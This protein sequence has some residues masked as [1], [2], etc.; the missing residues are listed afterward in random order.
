MKKILLIITLIFTVTTI[1]T[2]CNNKKED[3]IKGKW[4]ANVENQRKNRENKE[5]DEYVLECNGKGQYDLKKQ[6]QDLA[7]ASYKI[8]KNT[9]TFYDEGRK[10]LALCKLINN[11]ELDCSEKSYYAY[12][13]IKIEQ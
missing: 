11:K 8:E 2:G 9:V 12:K 3:I 1:I 13:Y 7:N 10:I 4:K 6:N 5:K